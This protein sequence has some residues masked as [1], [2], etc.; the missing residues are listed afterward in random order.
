MFA[1][2]LPKK[3]KQAFPD[4]SPT[5]RLSG[6]V[7]AVITCRLLF[8]AGRPMR[9]HAA[10]GAIHTPEA[11]KPRHAPIAD[12]ARYDQLR[13]AGYGTDPAGA[14]AWNSPRRNPVFDEPD[15][16]RIARGDCPGTSS[17]S[18]HARHRPE[19][20]APAYAGAAGAASW[21]VP[22]RGA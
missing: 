9:V 22:A 12:C 10:T 4:P 5:T 17:F 14:A 16:I 8:Q 13:R 3:Y 19:R 20:F 7:I 11:L 18:H 2:Q 6:V 15:D 21:T 1:D